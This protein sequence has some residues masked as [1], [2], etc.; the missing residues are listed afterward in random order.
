METMS[1]DPIR[2]VDAADFRIWGQNSSEMMTAKLLEFWRKFCPKR[3]G[4][5][6]ST[7]SDT[8]N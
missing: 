3:R 5:G 1:G 4:I 7:T 2:E 8:T 6:F